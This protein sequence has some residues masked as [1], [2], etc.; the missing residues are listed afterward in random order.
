MGAFFA[1]VEDTNVRPA[2]SSFVLSTAK[3]SASEEPA[4]SSGVTPCVCKFIVLFSSASVSHA[5]TSGGALP[6]SRDAAAS[7][8][9]ESASAR[10]SESKPPVSTLRLG[11]DAS[12]SASS[13]PRHVPHSGHTSPRAAAASDSSSSSFAVAAYCVSEPSALKNAAPPPVSTTPLR[14]DSSCCVCA[15]GASKRTAA[16]RAPPDSSHCA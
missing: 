1:S 9:G 5:Q 11:P 6:H 13:W 14:L 12:T 15:A 10:F 7:G 16:T 2:R 4:K 8:V 3:E